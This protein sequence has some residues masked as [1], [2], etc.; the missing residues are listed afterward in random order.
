[1]SGSKAATATK[2]E[3][4]PETSNPKTGIDFKSMD[5]KEKAAFFESLIAQLLGE[6]RED[7]TSEVEGAL[8]EKIDKELT[9]QVK[10]MKKGLLKEAV[11]R[12]AIENAVSNLD[13]DSIKEIFNRMDSR[14]LQ[15]VLESDE[16]QKEIRRAKKAASKQLD[17][18]EN[19]FYVKRR[20]GKDDGMFKAAWGDFGGDVKAYCDRPLGSYAR[21]VPAA[22]IGYLGWRAASG[23]WLDRTGWAGHWA[24]DAAAPL[25]AVILVESIAAIVRNWDSTTDEDDD[26]AKKKEKAKKAKAQKNRKPEA[27]DDDE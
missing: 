17:M 9:A 2:A 18:V 4:T 27:D 22:L 10:K 24:A 7:L 26:E 15:E 20:P 1:M 5:K 3:A 13:D 6:H 23:L 14:L 8:I 25:L 19:D 11:I 16:F 12:Q 21:V